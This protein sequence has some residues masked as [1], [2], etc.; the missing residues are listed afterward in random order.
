MNVM[1]HNKVMILK[2][3]NSIQWVGIWGS[4]VFWLSLPARNAGLVEWDQTGGP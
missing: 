2:K 3:K 4:V 1:D